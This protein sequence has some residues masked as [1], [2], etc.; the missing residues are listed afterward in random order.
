[1]SAWAREEALRR[2]E[3]KEAALKDETVTVT[4]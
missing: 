3:E 1:M 4:D 2:L